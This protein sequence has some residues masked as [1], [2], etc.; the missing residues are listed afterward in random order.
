MISES[1]KLQA[2]GIY[3]VDIALFVI[4]QILC[5]FNCVESTK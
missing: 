3:T 4:W 2:S 1:Y 5:L